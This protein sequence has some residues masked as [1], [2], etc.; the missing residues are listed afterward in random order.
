MVAD[1][2]PS[3]NMFPRLTA[4]TPRLRGLQVALSSAGSGCRFAVD[5]DR[6]NRRF[7]VRPGSGSAAHECAVLS[8]SFIGDKEVD[9][10]STYVPEALRGQ[11]V[12]ALLSQVKSIHVP[13]P[14]K[15]SFLIECVFTG[16]RGVS[17]GRK[18]E[19]SRLLLVHPEIHGGASTAAF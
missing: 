7:T 18:P 19:G 14:V 2:D 17:G 8:Y 13:R 4:L 6:Q 10:M 15:V 5:H 9:L 16:C 3:S 11:G 12:A 1:R